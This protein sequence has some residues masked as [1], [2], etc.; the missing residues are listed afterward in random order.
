M[1]IFMDRHDVAEEITAEIVAEIHQEDLKIQHKYSCKGITYWYDDQRKT[2]FCLVE[3]PNKEA[4]TEMHAQAHG[5]VPNTIIEVDTSIVES[6]LG[7]IE[8]P[9][10]SQ[11]KELNII[12]NPAFR[13]LC[14]IHLLENSIPILPTRKQYEIIKSIIE[15]A[16]GRL[17][18][19]DN[20]YLLVSFT[21]TTQAI[22]TA[23]A[24]KKEFTVNN[25]AKK[26]LHFGISAG[27]PVTK[28]H[29]FF[30]ETLKTAIRL[31][32]I[33]QERVVITSEVKELYESENQNK[34]L[35]ARL[36]KTLPFQDERFLNEILDY[37]DSEW[38]NPHLG[39]DD[40]CSNLGLSTSQLYRKTKNL[41]KSSTNNLVQ[42][43][44]LDEAFKL[45]VKKDRHISEIAFET[46]FNSAAYFTKCFR[47]RYN[48]LPSNYLKNA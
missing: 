10:K 19:G 5:E 13:I 42:K 43:K 33:S 38:Q 12:N 36:F 25:T 44:R 30:E 27:V 2:A 15:N 48:I 37:L 31:A 45:L 11:K 39:V 6:F 17:I 29:G 20:S 40:F 46:G 35:D 9:D 26:F 22:T 3:A 28:A 14:V 23:I 1:P 41:F 24:I 16:G 21:S 34:K 8:D 18:N 47:N 7:R 4:I 32:S